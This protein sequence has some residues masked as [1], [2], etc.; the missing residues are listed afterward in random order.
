MEKRD[1]EKERGVEERRCDAWGT[2]CEVGKKLGLTLEG[3][4]KFQSLGDLD[5]KLVNG[6]SF[7]I[8]M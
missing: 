3:R 1:H 5:R 6:L 7:I 2:E 4:A 8:D